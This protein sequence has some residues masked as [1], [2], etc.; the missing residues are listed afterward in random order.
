MY[1]H[2]PTHAA[3]VVL[4]QGSCVYLCDHAFERTTAAVGVSGQASA[5]SPH[6]CTHGLP[7]RQQQAAATICEDAGD[8]RIG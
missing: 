5:G 4:S 8:L 2:A 3:L 7:A 1:M 6:A